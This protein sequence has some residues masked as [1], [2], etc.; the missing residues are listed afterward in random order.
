[1]KVLRNKMIKSLIIIPV[2][3][4]VMFNV[5][6]PT[7]VYATKSSEG[8][9]W[10]FGGYVKGAITQGILGLDY[11]LEGNWSWDAAPGNLIKEIMYMLCGIG[12]VIESLL[13]V[14]MIGDSDFWLST[15]ISNRNDNLDNT[16]S[17]LYADQSDVDALQNGNTTDR[18]SV[19]VAINEKGLSG[20][21]LGNW[22]VPN[23]MYSPEMIFSNQVAALDANFI[24]P[25]EYNSI[26]DSDEAKREAVSLAKTVGPTIAN[27]YRAFRNLSIVGLLTVLVYI[28]I[29]IVIGSTAG[30]KA[31][32]KERIQDWF[33]ALCLVFF[34]HFIMAAIM[35]F[36]DKL[37]SLFNESVN[38][39]IIVLVSDGTI[40]KTNFTGLV[41]FFAQS[42]SWKMAFGYGV[43]FLMIIGIT[44]RYTW[45]YLRRFFFLAFFTMIAPAIALTYPLDKI[46][47]GKAQAYN[48]WFKEY[49]VLALTQPMHL[50][51]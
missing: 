13:Q 51:L 34:M 21:I 29:R 7:K 47:D 45:I 24:H 33:V 41:R 4:I 27:W 49:V 14:V 3:I 31:K 8:M 10:N 38:S 28:G 11:D 40:F 35:T 32:Y 16:D 50:I 6:I 37:V 5:F 42:A 36:S 44:V 46:N 12:D 20:G 25:N 48:K 18:G 39:G 19:L 26:T 22:E 2:I 9:L 30:E 43:M 1:M 17:W 15:T 23:M